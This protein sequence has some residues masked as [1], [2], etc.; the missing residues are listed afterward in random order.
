[1]K[2]FKT[3]FGFL[4]LICLLVSCKKETIISENEN[5][6]FAINPPIPKADIKYAEYKINP[7]K[8]TIIYHKSGAVLEI[9]KNAF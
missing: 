3:Y 4:V 9:P 8:D 7:N 2:T 5:L 6:V 1:M